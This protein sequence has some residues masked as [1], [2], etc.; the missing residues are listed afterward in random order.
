M[1]GNSTIAELRMRLN[2]EGD[3]TQDSAGAAAAV[4]YWSNT[5]LLYYLNAAVMRLYS[6]LVDLRKH[7]ELK[8][9]I[10]TTSATSVPADCYAPFAATVDGV[11]AV[12]FDDPRSALYLF[13]QRV[14][15]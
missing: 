15:A 4:Y 7:N 5:E 10:A 8:N 2:D 12:L 3:D 13:S 14:K 9:L 11:H 1:T 6:T